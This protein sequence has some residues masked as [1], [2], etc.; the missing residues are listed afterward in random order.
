M[1]T[2]LPLT[3][4][5]DEGGGHVAQQRLRPGYFVGH[6]FA[7][8]TWFTR[9][10]LSVVQF[11]GIVCRFSVGPCRGYFECSGRM[12]NGVASMDRWYR[13]K[14]RRLRIHGRHRIRKG[15]SASP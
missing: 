4:R 5:T 8:S 7:S 11:R 9:F 6:H 14:G 15:L 1:T 3:R 12:T 10:R 2:Q 13:N